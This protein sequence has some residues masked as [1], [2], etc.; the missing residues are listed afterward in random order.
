M[1]IQD[2]TNEQKQPETA[3]NE[4]KSEMM[5]PLFATAYDNHM[6]KLD[7]LQEQ[8]ADVQD[9][10]TKNE[11]K[12][13][14]FTEKADRPKATNEMPT[15]LMDSGKL[16]KSVMAIVRT[17]ETKINAIEEHKIPKLKNGIKKSNS[18][19][20]NLDN[21]IS[22]TKL[23]AEKLRS[24]SNIIR[25]FVTPNPQKR[26][27][28]FRESMESLRNSSKGLL[29]ME[30]TAEK[31][32]FA[33]LSRQYE[34]TDS[35][36]EKFKI[37]RKIDTIKSNISAIEGKIHKLENVPKLDKINDHI[38][39]KTI[40]KT[41]E[42]IENTGFMKNGEIDVDKSIETAAVNTAEYLKNT[43]MTMEDDMNMIDGII[44]NGMKARPDVSLFM[45][46]IDFSACDD[47]T[48][49]A[50]R[51]SAKANMACA[52]EIGKAINKSYDYENHMANSEQA[53]AT[54][55]EQFSDDRIAYVLANTLNGR[56]DGRLSQEVKD[57]AKNTIQK[58][59][60]QFRRSN[61]FL[62]SAHIGLV[63]IFAQNFMK[64]QA[65]R[66]MEKPVQEAKAG[67]FSIEMNGE[68]A[69]MTT[70]N[71]SCN[72]LLKMANHSEKPYMK[73][74]QAGNRISEMAYAEMEQSVNAKFSVDINFDNNEVHLM[75]INGGKGGIAEGDRNDQNVYF[76]TA[77]LSD[78][79]KSEVQQETPKQTRS[80]VRK[81]N[82]D[83][84]LTLSK[85][86]RVIINKPAKVG[87][88]IMTELE[89]QKI[90][91]SAV[92]TSKGV[93][94]TVSKEN[95]DAF[96]MVENKAKDTHV[97]L[98]HPKI[99][100]EIPKEERFIKSMPEHEAKETMQKLENAGVK[101]STRLDSDKSAITVKKSDAPAFFTRKQMKKL[102]QEVKAEQAPQDKTKSKK[103]EL[104]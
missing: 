76:H 104:S 3:E 45:E 66:E 5:L 22:V 99:F 56:D 31:S 100:K 32:R 30:M 46:E 94:I 70:E 55:R 98:I 39:D 71:L 67:L 102:A 65:E 47:A 64:S 53:L 17:N 51:D 68:K 29:Q 60:N 86:D 101:F 34:N 92:E 96:K 40:T 8:K 35:M 93:S 27:E 43:E 25:S 103:Q 15:A 54:V 38:V 49:Q 72:E 37:G 63:N 69:Y 42:E 14:V 36:A 26:R 84:Y 2:N 4:H 23:K 61:L 89:K 81:I 44:N 77:K 97:R 57:F 18:K 13:D 20:A 9:K 6:E 83:D 7:H 90:P 10:I 58:V 41:E 62:D 1:P 87:A 19:I 24:F 28:L 52:T 74:L 79:S 82:P 11:H 75:A 59:P 88:M 33:Q 50:F 91:F 21:R 73:L 95:K 80:A 12:I 78:F 16:L 85:Q 48:L